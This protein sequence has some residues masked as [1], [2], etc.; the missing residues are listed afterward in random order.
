MEFSAAFSL[1]RNFTVGLPMT[2]VSEGDVVAVSNYLGVDLPEVS[3]QDRITIL[4]KELS[5][6]NRFL[7]TKLES[8]SIFDTD[9]YRKSGFIKEVVANNRIN[10]RKRNART[11]D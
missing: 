2:P 6:Q 4:S 11:A 10:R 9:E 7:S 1:L 5:A 3:L 8:E